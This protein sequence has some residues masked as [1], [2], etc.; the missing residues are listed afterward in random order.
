MSIDSGIER[1]TTFEE[2]F[3]NWSDRPSMNTYVTDLLRVAFQAGKLTA[4]PATVAAVFHFTAMDETG[5]E[6]RGTIEA[7]TEQEAQEKIRQSGRFLTSAFL[8]K[9][10]TPPA[11]P[12]IEGMGQVVGVDEGQYWWINER[13]C[14]GCEYLHS[15]SSFETG[16]R[17]VRIQ[18]PTFPPRERF[19]A[20]P[21]PELVLVMNKSNGAMSWIAKSERTVLG[22]VV[23]LNPQ[24]GEPLNKE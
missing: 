2:W 4:E 5:T 13:D 24:T 23:I 7:A 19:T 3:A 10:V 16:S 1:P 21:R 18:Q 17:Y 12:V 11:S 9:A 6:T 22:D 15:K 20:P 14:I 8:R